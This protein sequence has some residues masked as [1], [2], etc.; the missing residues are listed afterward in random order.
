[1]KCAGRTL[2][3]RDAK[4]RSN[5]VS[6]KARISKFSKFLAVSGMTILFT[7]L[8]ASAQGKKPA[9]DKN[10]K[11]KQVLV[12]DG[13]DVPGNIVAQVDPKL[14]GKAIGKSA[15]GQALPKITETVSVS[16]LE[17]LEGLNGVYND[18]ALYNEQTGKFSI[19]TKVPV[20]GKNYAFVVLAVVNS[21]TA[22]TTNHLAVPI[23]KNEQ[24]I[25]EKNHVDL[26]PLA[27]YYYDMTG[28]ELK[29]VKLVAEKGYDEDAGAYVQVFIVPV[30]ELEGDIESGVPVCII[31]Y[32][33]G[34]L[35]NELYGVVE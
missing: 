1:M 18:I 33:E 11:T 5:T 24:G 19:S 31:A 23:Y 17:K 6:P 12:V 2:R 28:K 8:P 13:K 26:Q 10:D 34:V 35:Y 27:D 22:K 20:P 15:V 30:G 29:F 4:P 14:I 32:T 7:L 16:E 21:E 9:D 3:K 25:E